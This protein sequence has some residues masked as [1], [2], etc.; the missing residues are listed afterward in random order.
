MYMNQLGVQALRDR[1]NDLLREAE[2]VRLVRQRQPRQERR[3]RT[4]W[5]LTGLG[6]R[7]TVWGWRLE[8][9]YGTEQRL[10]GTVRETRLVT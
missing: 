8:E 4:R 9:R 1:Q 5:L 10:E 3:N 6:R 2:R 7:M